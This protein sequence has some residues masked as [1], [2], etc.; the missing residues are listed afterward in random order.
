MLQ[1]QLRPMAEKDFA[2]YM[3]SAVEAY[4]KDLME[5]DSLP[6]EQAMKGAQD[7]YGRLLPDGL[8]SEKQ[9]LFS[10]VDPGNQSIKGMVW[11]GKKPGTKDTAFIYDISV[12]EGA[13]GQGLGK[14]LLA[15]AEK[16]I[17][18]RGMKSVGLHVFGHNE[19]AI[20]LYKRSGFRTTN[21]IMH[22]NL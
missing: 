11:F 6:P 3:K 15:L 19:I 22:K 18:A 13:R 7:S 5:S 12:A 9:W 20:N 16:E 1:I 14:E 17:I 2:I 10:A 21:L 4:A 8:A